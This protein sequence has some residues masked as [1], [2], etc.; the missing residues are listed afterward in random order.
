MDDVVR[1]RSN[2]NRDHGVTINSVIR[3]YNNNMGVEKIILG[4]D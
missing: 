2:L 1:R 3:V 4:E